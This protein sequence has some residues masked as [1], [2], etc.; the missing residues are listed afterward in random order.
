MGT[1]FRITENT[2]KAVISNHAS[3]TR[4]VGGI[5]P[6]S[7]LIIAA[8]RLGKFY[9]NSEYHDLFWHKKQRSS[10]EKSNDMSVLDG[11]GDLLVVRFKSAPVIEYIKKLKDRNN[12]KSL[13][14]TLLYISTLHED[15]YKAEEFHIDAFLAYELLNID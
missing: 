3:P 14:E 13:K 10:A 9:K 7:F 11:E 6:S 12:H 2:W 8:G 4:G 1:N 5:Y 15:M